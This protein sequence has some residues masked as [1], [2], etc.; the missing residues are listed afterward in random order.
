[1]SNYKNII[2]K[3][4]NHFSVLTLNMRFGLADDGRNSWR[5]RKKALP[6]LFKKY[7]ADFIGVQEANDFQSDFLETILSEYDFIGKRC[8]SPPFW[9]NNIIF[10]KKIWKCIYNEHFFLSPTPMVP[11]RSRK[12]KWPRQCTIGMFKNNGRKLICINTH[13]DFD[14]AV[15]NESARLIMARL[16]LLPP[17]IPSILSGDFNATPVSS[18]YK[19]FTGQNQITGQKHPCYKNIFK[20]PFPG[21][22]HKFTGNTDGKHIDW[23]LYRNNIVPEKCNVLH[24]AFDNVYPSDHFPIFATFK[25][26]G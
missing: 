11:S 15:Q 7:R 17:D 4:D 13:F 24:G 23:I 19:I 26:E 25:W 2:N 1:M 9:Q 6:V 5:Y 8:P 14:D 20:E 3:A 21:T 12:S 10:Y 22:H 18:C 16:S